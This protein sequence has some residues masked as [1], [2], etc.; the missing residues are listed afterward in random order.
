MGFWSRVADFA[1]RKADPAG[2]GFFDGAGW[3]GAENA[4][5]VPVNSFSAMQ[6]VAVMA[7]VAIL[8]EDVAKLP[9]G[10]YRRRTDGGKEPAKDHPLYRLL[11]H[12]NRWQTRLEF[13]E[14]MQS[15]LVLRSNA[16]AVI[17]RNERGV[18]TEL[19]PVYPDRVSLYE[20]PGGDWF[21]WVSRMGLHE[22]AVLGSLP[23]MIHHEDMFHLKWMSSW[24]S[25]FGTPRISLMV[26]AIG[27][28]IGQEKLSAGLIGAGAR[29]SGA[30]QTDAKLSKEV[31]DRTKAQWQEVYGGWRNAGK[32]VVLEEGLKWEPLMMSMVDAE[33]MASRAYQLRDI[34]RGFRVP[35]HKLGIEGESSGPSMVQRDQ[36]YLNSVLSTY[37]ERWIAKAE[38][39][40]GIDGEDVF[41]AFD[42]EHFL[43]ADIMT[44]YQV[45]RLGVMSGLLTPNE[46]RRQEDLPDDPDGNKLLQPANMVPL[47]TPPAQ[48]GEGSAPGS[49]G[50]GLPAEGGDGDPAQLP[51]AEPPTIPV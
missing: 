39:T 28:G 13:V 22:M 2:S 32:T 41:L 6:H 44:R 42:Y 18:P 7:C 29:P 20:A 27:L 12:P 10:I 43:K 38:A 46:F 31:I 33:F 34:A 35:P 14:M 15:A 19:V 8:S 47:G 24:N 17:I 49:D 4:S 36:D 50:T 48:K 37:C 25:L 5:G 16:Y 26:E 23:L 9:L 11:K 3:G 45:A 51:S 40:F 1:R 30:L 21:Y